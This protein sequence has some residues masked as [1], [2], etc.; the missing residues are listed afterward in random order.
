MPLPSCCFHIE[1][2]Q[3]S[4]RAAVRVSVRYQPSQGEFVH[5]QLL[6]DWCAEDV[7]GS[8]LFLPVN[9]LTTRISHGICLSSLSF[10]PL[11]FLVPDWRSGAKWWSVKILKSELRQGTS[12]H[13]GKEVTAFSLCSMAASALEQTWYTT[14]VIVQLRVLHFPLSLPLLV[15]LR[16]VGKDH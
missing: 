12:G 1:M 16:G 11:F 7:L 4:L 14:S 6:W 2:S 10:F 13:L 9:Y 3:L 5:G 8:C 15:F